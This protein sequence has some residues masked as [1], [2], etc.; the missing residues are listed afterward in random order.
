M[1]ALKAPRPDEL[2]AFFYQSQ[3][4]VVEKSIC[5]MIQHLWDNSKCIEQINNISLVLAYH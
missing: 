4:G 1:G 5:K 3:W 2:N